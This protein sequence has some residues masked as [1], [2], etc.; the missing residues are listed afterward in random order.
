MQVEKTK[1][2][3]ETEERE[4]QTMDG[5]GTIMRLFSFPFC[6][7]CVL[8]LLERLPGGGRSTSPST[9]K[10]KPGNLKR[11]PGGQRREP[12]VESAAPC[13]GGD[14]RLGGGRVSCER[15]PANG[16]LLGGHLRVAGAIRLE[17]VAL[18]MVAELTE[19]LG[20]G[21]DTGGGGVAD[22]V[23]VGRG[24]WVLAG[25]NFKGAEFSRGMA[26]SV[27][28]ELERRQEAFPLAFICLDIRA[29]HLLERAVDTLGLA[30]GLG[31]I[32]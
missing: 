12:H 30:V 28:G 10:A 9:R 26:G 11:G 29:E 21:W 32:G 3:K 15:K 2:T 13:G 20:H 17:D 4:E 19:Q 24:E 27:V 7:G 18:R 5:G 1:R 16:R 31:V 25:H 8:L 6:A 14:A 22:D 23:E